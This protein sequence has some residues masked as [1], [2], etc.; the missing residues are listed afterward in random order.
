MKKF[1]DFLDED[2]KLGKSPIPQDEL[3]RHLPQMRDFMKKLISAGFTDE[4]DVMKAVTLAWNVF[5]AQLTNGKRTL[6]K[7]SYGLLIKDVDIL[8]NKNK[9]ELPNTDIENLC[10]AVEVFASRYIINIMN[11][12]QIS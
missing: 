5:L 11:T 6:I 4:N 1:N 12:L 3:N 2:L 10:R 7:P 9:I 8:I